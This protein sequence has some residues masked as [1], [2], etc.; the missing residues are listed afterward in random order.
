MKISI[1]DIGLNNLNSVMSACTKVGLKVNI[2]SDYKSLIKSDAI[3][4][5]GVGAFNH[6]MKNLKKNNLDE[7]IKD[8]FKEGKPIFGICL[9]M[10]ILFSKSYENGIHNGLGIIKGE[11]KK[12]D[13]KFEIVPNIGW[14]KIKLVNNN[15][16]SL[17]SNNEKFFYFVHSFYCSPND[18]KVISS[19]S[20]FGNFKFCSSILKDNI[21]AFQFH[22]EKSGKNGLKIYNS[23]KLKLRRF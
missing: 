2:I 13:K 7:G 22:P 6:A 16:G 21:E 3:L 12:F 8:Y 5:P 10:Q 11:V 17:I 15:K 18:R 1:I 19:N 20:S 4:L 9:G 14:N 23:I